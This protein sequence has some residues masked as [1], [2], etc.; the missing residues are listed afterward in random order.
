MLGIERQVAQKPIGFGTFTLVAISSCSAS[1]IAII[2][3]P[4]NPLTLLSGAI[5]GISFLGAGS[6]IK[7]SDGSLIQ[8]IIALFSCLLTRVSQGFMTAALLVT[9]AF[10][11][12]TIGAGFY[13]FGAML[14]AMCIVLLLVN[15]LFYHFR[16]GSSYR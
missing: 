5:S 14:W 9:S 15:R 6:L 12:L 1:I 13:I 10:I 4:A 2:M 8:G 3:V 16:L 11:G 7:S